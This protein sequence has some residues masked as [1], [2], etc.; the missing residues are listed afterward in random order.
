MFDTI[1]LKA[2][3][4]P[5]DPDILNQYN[6]HSTTFFSKETGAL[7]TSYTLKDEKLPYMKYIENSQTLTIQVSMPK[8]LY[9]DNV[10]MLTEADIP[11]FFEQLQE[12]LL[13]LFDVHIPHSEWIISRC[14]VCCNFQVG[15]KV[16]EYVRM[17]SR[18]Q[19][20]Y[21]NTIAYNQDQTVEYRNKSSRIMLYDK[22]KQTRKEE[23]SNEIIERSK[24]ILRLEVRPSDNDLRRFSPTRKA[25]ELLQKP[26]FDYTMERTL[27]QIEYPEEVSDM[28]L[29][30]LMENRENISKIEIVL[31]FQLLQS[32]FDESVLRQLYTSSTYAN[33]KNLAKKIAIPKGNCLDRLAINS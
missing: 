26:F 20:A 23:E 17:L 30:W 27:A 16:S 28:D 33:R 4:I 8:F 19:L 11:L 3:P 9:G 13:Q 1:I 12:R 31:G 29:S 14:D 25:V 32:K 21:K 2:R 24:G 7:N 22:H 10:T 5:I 6:G 18:Q 15:K